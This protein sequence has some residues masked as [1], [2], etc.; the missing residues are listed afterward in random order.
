MQ[1]YPRFTRLIQKA[2]LLSRSI[3]N[4]DTDDMLMKRE[5]AELVNFICSNKTLEIVR[6]YL[7]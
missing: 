2:L 7:S 1:E 5:T 3:K 4:N 6:G